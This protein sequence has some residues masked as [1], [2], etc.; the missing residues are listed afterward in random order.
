[1]ISHRG[2]VNSWHRDFNGHMNVQH[3]MGKFDEATW[4][5][6][7]HLGI[8]P[9]YMKAHNVGMFTV[10]Q[11]INYFHELVAGD[12]IYIKTQMVEF[13]SKAI[14]FLGPAFVSAPKKKGCIMLDQNILTQ[15]LETEANLVNYHWEDVANVPETFPVTQHSLRSETIDGWTEAVLALENIGKSIKD[16]QGLSI[17]D[18][19]D[20]DLNFIS[21]GIQ[22]LA[23][24][25]TAIEN[26]DALSQPYFLVKTTAGSEHL[27]LNS[28]QVGQWVDCGFEMLVEVAATYDFNF[29][30]FIKGVWDNPEDEAEID[31]RWA[32]R[33]PDG[34]YIARTESGLMSYILGFESGK[35]VGIQIYINGLVPPSKVYLSNQYRNSSMTM[36]QVIR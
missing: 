3:Y 36:K 6:Y 22:K 25:A 9:S 24:I 17:N 33:N 31:V 5:F 12:L 34:G 2:T 19:Q 21:P 18:I 16:H 23:D 10:E 15:G 7:A 32:V 1:M 8:T 29:N 4:H 27:I 30:I 13:K 11:N 20:L 26:M 28:P 35:Y 14:V